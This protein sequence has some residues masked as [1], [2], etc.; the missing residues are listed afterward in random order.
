MQRVNLDPD[1]VFDSRQ[2]GFS[3]AVVTSGGRRVVLSGQVA[4]DVEERTIGDDLAAQ[5]PVVFD[6][7]ERVLAAAGAAAADVVMLRIYLV[8]AVREQQQAVTDELL[9]RFPH[10]P[11]ATSWVL[12]SGLSEPE[13]LVEVEAEAVVVDR[14]GPVDDI[15]VAAEG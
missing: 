13:W 7:I 8:D 2:Y 9:R 14:E 5:L 3:Q 12:V 15:G 1:D 11:P 10:D 6:N 4:A